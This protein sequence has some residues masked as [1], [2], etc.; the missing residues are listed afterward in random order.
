MREGPGVDQVRNAHDLP[1]HWTGGFDLVLCCEMLE[2][3][4]KFWQSLREIRRVLR[5]GGTMLLTTRGNGFPEHEFPMDL[6]RFMPQ[7][8]ELLC[9]MAGCKPTEVQLDP[10]QPGIFVAGVRVAYL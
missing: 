10:E 7:S 3:D 5:V 1:P 4:D 9:E 6:W 2:H 8:G